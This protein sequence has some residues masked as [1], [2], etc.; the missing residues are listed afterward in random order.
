MIS[1]PPALLR[2]LFKSFGGHARQTQML[3]LRRSLVVMGMF[4]A[5]LG[6]AACGA[7][8]SGAVQHAAPTDTKTLVSRAVSGDTAA[9]AVLRAQREAGLQAVLAAYDATSDEAQ[10]AALRPV[11]DAVARQRD[12]HVSRLYWYTNVIDAESAAKASGKPILALQLLG[13]LDEELSC[14]NSRFFRTTL[15][16][17]REVADYLRAHFVLLWQ[18]ERPAPTITIDYRD[19]RKVV[20]TITGNSIHYVLDEDGRPVDAL[21][22]LYGP[23]AWKRALE[24]AEALALATRGT[25]GAAREALMRAYHR[26]ANEQIEKRFRAEVAQ[27]GLAS[28]PLP[29]PIPGPMGDAQPDLGAPPPALVAMNIAP[30]KAAVEMRPLRGFMPGAPPADTTPW[31]A[32]ASQHRT[33]AHID[34]QSKALIREKH[35]RN[36]SDPASPG[37]PLSE[38][39]LASL[40]EAFETSMAEDT[41][42][43]ELGIHANIHRWLAEQPLDLPTLNKHVY[44]TLFR[45]PASDPWLGLVPPNAYTGLSDDGIKAP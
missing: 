3:S 16:A 36:W 39:E 9:I 28:L 15:Y 43:N 32:L 6:G 31:N 22:G 42:K 34:A 2:S 1:A 25:K 45:T 11:I 7:G 20:R 23:Q 37:R 38:T 13:N 10:K 8:H 5:L 30:S 35:P 44:D 24:H 40:Y 14:A 12:A 26:D 19:G 41:A 4:A 29:T 17:N 33:E 21:P 27:I 18:S